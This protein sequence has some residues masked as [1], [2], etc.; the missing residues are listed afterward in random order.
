[1]SN[2]ENE[3]NEEDSDS[4]LFDDAFECIDCEKKVE[5]ALFDKNGKCF[6]SQQCLE[7]YNGVEEQEE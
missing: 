2:F 7:N 4:D 1:M 6:C 5:D 3:R